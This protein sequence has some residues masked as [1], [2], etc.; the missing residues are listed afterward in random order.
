MALAYDLLES[1]PQYV[2]GPRIRT[3]R[4]LPQKTFVLSRSQLLFGFSSPS[5]LD[6]FGP[7]PH[8]GMVLP[9]LHR[10]CSH[11]LYPHFRVAVCRYKM[12]AMVCIQV[13]LRLEAYCLLSQS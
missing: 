4:E 8:R 13:R 7:E 10:A 11:R 2:P 3:F 12:A 1:A 9:E 5:S 6:S